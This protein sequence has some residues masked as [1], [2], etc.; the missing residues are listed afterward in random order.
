ML[1]Y[2]KPL[3]TRSPFAAAA[4]FAALLPL[5]LAG[6]VGAQTVSLTVLNPGFE[7]LTGADPVHFTPEGAL[8]EGHFAR[9]SPNG[10]PRLFVT[11]DPVPGWAVVGA[12]VGSQFAP[13]TAYTSPR[14]PEGQ[15]SAFIG[16]TN[17]GF[18]SL[19]QTLPESVAAGVYSLTV[20]IGRRT[21]IGFAGYTVELL[22]GGV[23]VAQDAGSLTPVSGGFV[24]SGVTWTVPAGAAVIG[25]PLAI[26]LSALDPSSSAQANFDNVRLT[27]TP[28]ATAVVPEPGTAALLAAVVA[29]PLLSAAMKRRRA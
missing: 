5:V 8:R 20:D 17:A 6:R 29:L 26:R 21:D 9:T 14:F 12:D 10:D 18:A 13:R 23:P 3:R 27:F 7:A 25:Q 16:G 11:P 24:T 2:K 28:A 15:N 1:V 22:A 19:T 4:V